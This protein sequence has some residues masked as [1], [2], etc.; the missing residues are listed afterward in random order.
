MSTFQRSNNIEMTFMKLN[1]QSTASK[2]TICKFSTEVEGIIGI[3]FECFEVVTRR[4]VA[5]IGLQTF[6]ESST[7]TLVFGSSTP[8]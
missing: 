8:K 5:T 7:S 6:Q 1:S 3:T 4:K 2:V